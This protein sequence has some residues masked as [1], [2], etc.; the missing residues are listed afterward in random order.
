MLAPN[1]SRKGDS[2]LL[3]VPRMLLAAE[4]SQLWACA[5][6]AAVALCTHLHCS[7]P[8]AALCY[9]S[10]CSCCSEDEEL[11]SVEQGVLGASRRLQDGYPKS[12]LFP[13]PGIP[14]A[15]SL[16]SRQPRIREAGSLISLSLS[17]HVLPAPADFCRHPHRLAGSCWFG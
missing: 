8:A 3:L 2:W 5:C 14:D 15:C 17:S 10:P 11:G 13:S 1:V 7:V 12:S 4:G 9:Y 6:R 16:I